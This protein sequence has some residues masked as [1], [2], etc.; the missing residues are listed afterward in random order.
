MSSLNEAFSRAWVRIVR[1]F[2]HLP[3]PAR[4]GLARCAAA[5]FWQA[6][7]K[8][9]HVILTNLR[10]CFPELSEDERIRLARRVYVRLAR[11]AIDHGTLWTGTKEEVQAL[12]KF[13]GLE[14]ILNRENRPII[15]VSPHFA[16]LDAAGI[17]LNTYVR[18]VSLYQKQSNPVW[19]KALL[20]G[21]LR[22]SNP[23]LIAK[24]GDNDL[25]TVMKHIREGLPFYYLPDMDHGARNS[26]FVPFFGVKAATI[27]MVS[28]LARVMRAKVVWCIATMTEDGYR[29]EISAPLE[30][31][32]TK[33]PEAD[34]M[35]LNK[36]LEAYIR[37]H[38]D[39][40]LWV[41]RRFKTRPEGEP[42]VY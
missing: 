12:V 16:G 26:I 39:Q 41:H 7:P 2:R 4:W 29:V 34:T 37:R 38:P 31:F 33:D 1:S 32:P 23:V 36:E 20:E 5:I 17:V 28:R 6:V 15:V 14:H 30:N 9:R 13:E 3:M 22:F 18:G 19:D 35:R 21:R 8:R 42:S 10:L 27:P 40:Y 11:A 25:R 24:T